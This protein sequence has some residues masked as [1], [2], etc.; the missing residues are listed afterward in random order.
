M[1]ATL[2]NLIHEVEEA[3]PVEA[4]L[5]ASGADV[6]LTQAGCRA[7]MPALRYLAWWTDPG[8][9]RVPAGVFR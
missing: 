1:N 9:A 7:T 6:G 8:R 2:A 5:E 4:M 3:R